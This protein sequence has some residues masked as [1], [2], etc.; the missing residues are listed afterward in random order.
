MPEAQPAAPPSRPA[1]IPIAPGAHEAVDR[2]IAMATEKRADRPA[3]SASHSALVTTEPGSA[4]AEAAILLPAEQAST[5]PAQ[6]AARIFSM[7]RPILPALAGALRMV[8]H[9]A[10]QAAARLLPLLA[11]IPA[12][13]APGTPQEQS[14]DSVAAVAALEAAQR[15]L[16]KE[17][18]GLT[19]E[20]ARLEGQLTQIRWKNAQLDN[21]QIAGNERLRDMAKRTRLLTYAV[22]LMLPMM[23]ALIVLLAI[24][25]RS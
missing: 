22:I 4:R 3:P 14:A 1:P 2:L 18:D 6:T 19:L 20:V 12:A 24:H 21:E 25:L 9:G 17:V 23:I 16:R 7:L 8:D 10:V 11:G 15:G 5:S 13:S